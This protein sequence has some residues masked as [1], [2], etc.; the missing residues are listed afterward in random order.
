MVI[1]DDSDCRLLVLAVIQQA[2]NDAHSTNRYKKLDAICWLLT[3]APELLDEMNVDFDTQMW[4]RWVLAGC[5]K[6]GHFSARTPRTRI[7]SIQGVHYAGM[8]VI[9]V[10]ER[11]VVLA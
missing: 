3:G 9:P 4:R 5:K 10:G 2:I 1:Q 7:P 11:E 8:V 6:R